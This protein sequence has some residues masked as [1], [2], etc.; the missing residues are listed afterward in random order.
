MIEIYI[1]LPPISWEPSRKGEF[2]FYDPKEKEKR[3][4]RYYIR[5]QY[6]SDPITDYVVIKLQFLFEIPK[7]YSKKKRQLALDHKIFPTKKD[8]TN[9]QKLYEDCLKGIVISDD[10]N[11]V[12]IFSE[13][14]Y[15]EKEGIN[16]FI[17]T[18]EEHALKER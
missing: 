8:C 2:T 7:S 10:R 6:D 15:S 16:I 5:E 3:V 13:K 17:E 9:M 12:K 11:V 18:L 4:V 1:P 14:E